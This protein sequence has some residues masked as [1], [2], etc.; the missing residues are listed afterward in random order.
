MISKEASVRECKSVKGK[1]K[2]SSQKKVEPTQLKNVDKSH[3]KMAKKAKKA[4]L[5]FVSFMQTN[6]IYPQIQYSYSYSYRYSHSHSRV[7][8]EYIFMLTLLFHLF[9]DLY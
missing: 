7:L 8:E 4:A 1:E 9:F 2:S 5:L 3:R 6:S